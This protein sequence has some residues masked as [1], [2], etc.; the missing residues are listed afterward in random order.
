M[1]LNQLLTPVIPSSSSSPISI[2][3]S[4]SNI[5]GN[6]NA[7]PGSV[8]ILFDSLNLHGDKVR[9]FLLKQHCVLEC[10][11]RTCHG[12]ALLIPVTYL[13]PPSRSLYEMMKEDLLA[14]ITFFNEKFKHHSTDRPLCIFIKDLEP[15]TSACDQVTYIVKSLK[16]AAKRCG[17]RLI[18]VHAVLKSL[19]PLRPV[20]QLF[21][22]IKIEH[23]VSCDFYLSISTFVLTFDLHQLTVI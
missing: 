9:K 3:Q 11:E 15:W 22:S 4:F 8:S 17:C 16:T 21:Q 23:Q 7:D 14:L 10:D 5:I 6:V 13:V 20:D 19:K 12:I 2:Q 1:L 18:I